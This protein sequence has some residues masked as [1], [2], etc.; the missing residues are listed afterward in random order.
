MPI[1]LVGTKVDLRNNKKPE[2]KREYDP[3]T[4]EEGE[5]LKKEIKVC[6]N[7]HSSLIDYFNCLQ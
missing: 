7:I 6:E 4:T 1:F 3:V 5:A 2:K